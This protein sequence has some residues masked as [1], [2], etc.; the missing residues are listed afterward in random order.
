MEDQWFENMLLKSKTALINIIRSERR[1][2][3]IQIAH[4]EE[5]IKELKKEIAEYQEREKIE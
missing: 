2:F 5:T 4:L 1:D 3:D